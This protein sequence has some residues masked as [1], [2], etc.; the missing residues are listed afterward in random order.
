MGDYTPPTIAGSGSSGPVQIEGN[1]GAVVNQDPTTDDLKV[2]VDSLPALPAG[3]NLIGSVDV[4]NF[5]ATQPVSGTV[6]VSNFPAT[7]PVS[8]SVTVGDYDLQGNLEVVNPQD[9]ALLDELVLLARSADLAND[10]DGMAALTS[11][12]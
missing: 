5:P 11:D 2:I 8:G 9:R 1:Q 10:R 4:A 12:R 6:A 3:A 7:Q